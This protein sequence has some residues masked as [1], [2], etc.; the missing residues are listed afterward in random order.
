M[1]KYFTM[2]L[3]C[4]ML[5]LMALGLGA[6]SN[7]SEPSEIPTEMEITEDNSVVI[8]ETTDDMVLEVIASSE[9]P[10]QDG[11]MAAVVPEVE[12]YCID[13]H[14]NQ[15]TLIDTA[16]PEGEVASENEGEG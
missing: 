7:R 3:V 12:N 2:I 11:D 8:S 13:C 4:L 15:Q 5:L 1:K 6:C 16:K 9:N 10:T 14:T